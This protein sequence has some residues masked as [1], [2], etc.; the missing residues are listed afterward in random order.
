MMLHPKKAHT[1][2]AA[3]LLSLAISTAGYAQQDKVSP[4]SKPAAWRVE[5]TGDGKTLECHAL[6]Q[7][8]RE[9]KRLAAVLTVRVPPEPKAQPVMMIQL[10]LGVSVAEPVQI[11]VDGGLTEK[12]PIQTC[13]PSGCFVGMPLNDKQVAAMRGGNLL[14]ITVQDS[15]KRPITVEVSLL[16]FGPALDKAK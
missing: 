3:L 11:Q 15:S 2:V 5:C 4:P 8:V 13:T 1:R 14:K 12:Q 16:G 6:Q 9:D 7:G 10:P